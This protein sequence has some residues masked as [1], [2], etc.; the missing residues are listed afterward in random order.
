[1]ASPTVSSDRTDAAAPTRHRR[2]G[3][4]RCLRHLKRTIGTF[5]LTMFGV[6][7]TVGTGIFFVLS[8]AVPE[9]GPAVLISFLSPASPPGW[10]PSVT[11]KWLRPYRFPARP[12]PTHTPRLGEVVAMGVAACLLL[13]YGVSTAGGRRRLEP[14]PQ[15]TADNLF[16][17][18]L[19]QAIISGTV[20]HDTRHRQPARD[21]PGRHVRAAADPRRQRVREGE[22]HH[23]ADQARRA[24]HVHRHRVH[25]I[26]R[27]PL[28][29]LRAD[30]HRRHRL[31][32]RDDL[33]LLHRARRRLTA[34]DEVKDPQKTMPRRSSPRC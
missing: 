29:Q 32:R 12:T 30:G 16:G 22:H 13:E 2:A 4:T 28:R 11:P 27:R 3:R 21:L 31:G 10:L 19:P 23:G 18:Q 33:L 25:R 15:Q 8:A 20:G 17:R 9:A 26:P 14:V 7:A 1:M 24:R 6:G 34:G 5:Q